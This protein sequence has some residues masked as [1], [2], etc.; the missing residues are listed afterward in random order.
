MEEDFVDTPFGNLGLTGTRG[1]GTVVVGGRVLEERRRV[2]R[3]GAIGAVK[4][5]DRLEVLRGGLAETAVVSAAMVGK[6]RRR[7]CGRMPFEQEKLQ[8]TRDSSS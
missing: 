6:G 7:Y 4:A 3:I 5:R 1:E 2:G 8:S